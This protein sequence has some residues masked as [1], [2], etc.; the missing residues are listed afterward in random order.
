M[1]SIYEVTEAFENK[2]QGIESIREYI[3]D[4]YSSEKKAKSIARGKLFSK[5]SKLGI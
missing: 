4:N 1:I 3:S 2:M 5:D